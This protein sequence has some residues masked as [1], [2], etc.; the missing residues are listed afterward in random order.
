MKR[1]IVK[2][3]VKA[4][5]KHDIIREPHSPFASPVVLVKKKR[6]GLPDVHRLPKIK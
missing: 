1:N 2:E 4:L 5:L 6:L 3:K